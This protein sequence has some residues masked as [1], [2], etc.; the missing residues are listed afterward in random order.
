METAAPQADP[1]P[2]DA[3]NLSHLL[4]LRV[5]VVVRLAHKK[6]NVEALSKMMVGTIIEFD[7]SANEE[8][9]VMIRDKPVGYGVAVRTGE[10]YGLR[11]TTLCDVREAIAAMGPQ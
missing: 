3:E 5:P 9:E 7:K 1:K 4:K 8:L 6:M 10:C 2:A 11:I